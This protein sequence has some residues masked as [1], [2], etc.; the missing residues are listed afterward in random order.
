MYE[1]VEPGSIAVDESPLTP[2]DSPRA[3]TLARAAAGSNPALPRAAAEGPLSIGTNAAI[4]S[5]P[6][7]IQANDL[8]PTTAKIARYERY[9]A[10]ALVY[11][12]HEQRTTDCMTTKRAHTHG[13]RARLRS[14]VPKA[15]ENLAR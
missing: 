4:T 14:V 12:Q 1:T 11:D 13:E 10:I 8:F 5:A 15:G 2:S 7:V 6:K 9:S 3:T